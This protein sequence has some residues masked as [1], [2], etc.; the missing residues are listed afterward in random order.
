MGLAIIGPWLLAQALSSPS[1]SDKACAPTP[2]KRL[3]PPNGLDPEWHG[4]SKG[5]SGITCFVE[6]VLVIVNPDGTVKSAVVRGSWGAGYDKQ[7]LTA[8]RNG[9]YIPAT[10]D[11]KP[12]EG[13]YVF[14]EMFV[15]VE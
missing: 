7:A 3:K 2:V 13:Q 6:E 12:V 11:C 14:H 10:A 4:G 5:C 8:A 15:V 9:N 1:P